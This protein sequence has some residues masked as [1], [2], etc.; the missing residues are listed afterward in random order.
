MEPIR[1]EDLL[2]V[3]GGLLEPQ[4]FKF[5]VEAVPQGALR[6][7]FI[8]QDFCSL[9]KF[10]RDFSVDEH[11]TKTALNFG[12]GKQSCLLGVAEVGVSLRASD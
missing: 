5:R 8:E 3:G 2:G 4:F 1:S 7:K 6:S 9:N 12:F 10:R 11:L